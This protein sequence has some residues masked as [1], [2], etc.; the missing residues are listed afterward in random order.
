LPVPH[1]KQGILLCVPTCASMVLLYYGEQRS[2]E[3]LKALAASVSSDPAFS[4]TYFVDLVK[5]MTKIGHHWQEKY[6]PVTD[7]GF[8]E[9]L[10]AITA[11]LNAGRPVL[12][13]TNIPPVGHTVLA[14]GYDPTHR[15]LMLLDPNMESPGIRRMSYNEFNGVWHSLTAYIRGTIFTYPKGKNPLETLS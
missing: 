3:S 8:E 1:L 6:Y 7:E 4:G 9:G 5:G 14:I 11:S 10:A 15:E 12:V 13:D 2:P